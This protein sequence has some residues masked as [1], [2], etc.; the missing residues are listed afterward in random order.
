LSDWAVTK[1]GNTFDRKNAS[2]FPHPIRLGKSTKPSVSHQ[3]FG[4]TTFRGKTSLGE[5]LVD[6][7]FL[8]GFFG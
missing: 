2:V 1:F 7:S 6:F 4:T 5:D 8:G 3:I